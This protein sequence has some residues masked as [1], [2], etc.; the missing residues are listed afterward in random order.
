MCGWVCWKHI[1]S[2]RFLVNS[3]MQITKYQWDA[4]TNLWFDLDNG[5]RQSNSRDVKNCMTRMFDGKCSLQ[6]WW[7]NIHWQ[8]KHTR[9]CKWSP[10]ALGHKTEWLSKSLLPLIQRQLH[11]PAIQG[12][13]HVTTCDN[14][15][16]H[17]TTCDNTPKYLNYFKCNR[18]SPA[19]A[20]MTK[21]VRLLLGSP[22]QLW[23]FQHIST[24]SRGAL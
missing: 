2:V 6:S 3:S 1:F 20:R 17:V 9:Q 19:P 22:E 23:T 10:N 11:L 14:M 7:P 13:Q 18:M 15:W 8:S 16:Q 12:W 24:F 5:C 4:G 21:T